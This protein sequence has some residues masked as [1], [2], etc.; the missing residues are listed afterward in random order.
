MTATKKAAAATATKPMGSSPSITLSHK[1]NWKNIAILMI[2]LIPVFS[3]IASLSRG[4]FAIGGEWFL[5]IAP[6]VMAIEQE[7]A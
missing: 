4:Y 1:L 2:A 7:N 3:V 6:M 5:W